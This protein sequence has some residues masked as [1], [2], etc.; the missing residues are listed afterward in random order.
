M[1]DV[2]SLDAF[3]K[4]KR[5]AL[6]AGSTLCRAGKHKWQIE[7]QTDFDSKQGKLVSRYRCER[8][9]KVKVKAL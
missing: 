8:C 9:G 6:A 1:S 2:R 5:K 7:K 4:K 3:R